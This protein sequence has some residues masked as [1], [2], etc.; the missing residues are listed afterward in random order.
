MRW[1]SA[2][3]A[4]EIAESSGADIDTLERAGDAVRFVEE[5]D[6]ECDEG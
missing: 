3:T 4:E 6:E 5:E 2:P 1:K